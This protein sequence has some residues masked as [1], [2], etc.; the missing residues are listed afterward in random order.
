[1]STPEETTR[2]K[3]RLDWIERGNGKKYEDPETMA[4]KKAR[5]HAI[6]ND[7][8][9]IDRSIPL[10]IHTMIDKVAELQKPREK[11]APGTFTSEREDEMRAGCS[12]EAYRDCGLRSENTEL[13]RQLTAKDVEIARWREISHK[14][15]TKRV[16][17]N[18]RGNGCEYRDSECGVAWRNF[19]DLVGCPHKDRFYAHAASELSIQIGQEADYI[20]RL[21][22]D[23]LS[24]VCE[25]YHDLGEERAIAEA[26]KALEK[27]R[28]GN[29]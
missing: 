1:M 21:E 29:K 7:G 11:D 3:A 16:H 9:K 26:K 25:Y 23:Y 28:A 27:I 10:P 13:H 4:A 14:E 12:P 17:Q 22:R 8:K 20:I 19:C 15:A 6:V 24:W 18:E 2:V 5:L